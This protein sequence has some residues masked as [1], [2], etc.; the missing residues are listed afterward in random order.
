MRP[1]I[2]SSTMV[3]VLFFEFFTVHVLDSSYTMQPL[4]EFNY[5]SGTQ[6]PYAA[7][8]FLNTLRQYNPSNKLFSYFKALLVIR[9]FPSYNRYK[10]FSISF[11]CTSINNSKNFPAERYTWTKAE[12]QYIALRD[13]VNQLSID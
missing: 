2:R 11:E 10:T 5:K 6:S 3:S 9:E 12:K 13:L 7:F 8:N 4:I 1:C